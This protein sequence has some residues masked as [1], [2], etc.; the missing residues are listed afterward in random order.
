MAGFGLGDQALQI[1]DLGDQEGLGG[2]RPRDLGCLA[3]AAA[4]GEDKRGQE[5][6]TPG[7]GDHQSARGRGWL[8][9]QAIV[10]LVFAAMIWSTWPSS[11]SWAIGTLVGISMLFNGM[12]RLMLSRAMCRS[13]A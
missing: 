9:F 1:G 12:C 7:C 8:L 10:A 11:A 4:E 5:A 13:V 3:R 6:R 2:A